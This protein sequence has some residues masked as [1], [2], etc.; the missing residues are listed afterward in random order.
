LTTLSESG[1]STTMPNEPKS[2]PTTPKET[3]SGE[4]V[5]GG[6]E[7]SKGTLTAIIVPVVTAVIGLIFGLIRLIYSALEYHKPK[8]IEEG[9]REEDPGIKYTRVHAK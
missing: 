8:Q 7:M 3:G 1:P 2:T 9:K 4:G 5:S 6:K